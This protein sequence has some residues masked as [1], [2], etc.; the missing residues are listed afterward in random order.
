[1][2]TPLDLAEPPGCDLTQGQ[3]QTAG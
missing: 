1:M 2:R 3:V